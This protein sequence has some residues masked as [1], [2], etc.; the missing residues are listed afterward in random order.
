V[1]AARQLPYETWTA[2]AHGPQP[3]TLTDNLG[4]SY[5]LKSAEPDWQMTEQPRRDA[6]S[7]GR[8]ADELLVF[9]PPPATADFLHLELPATACGG[10]DTYRLAIPRAL[11]KR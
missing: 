11:I 7:P 3:P 8:F 4:K 9:E 6:V 10:R 2:A 5:A 1:G